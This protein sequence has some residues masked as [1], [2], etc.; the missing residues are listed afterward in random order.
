MYF[1]R[2]RQGIWISEGHTNRLR[3]GK[4][5]QHHLGEYGGGDVLPEGELVF[6][7]AGL[8]ELVAANAL[9]L[10]PEGLFGD[11]HLNPTSIT[12]IAVS[13]YSMSLADRCQTCSLL[14]TQ[15]CS[16]GVGMNLTHAPLGSL[17]V[18]EQRGRWEAL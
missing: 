4:G 2:S 12:N 9:G 18:S 11:L 10:N 3:R 8:A 16:S 15:V 14:P 13:T 1:S 17:V 6:G 7:G 5:G